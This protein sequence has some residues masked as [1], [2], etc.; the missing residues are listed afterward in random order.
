MSVA[1]ADRRTK[2]PESQRRRSEAIDRANLALWA[3]DFTTGLQSLEQA[4]QLR[5]APALRVVHVEAL[6]ETGQRRAAADLAM[7]YIKRAAA[8]P[9]FERPESDPM[10]HMLARA[11][12]GGAMPDAD[13]TAQREAWLAS[14]RARLDDEA[15]RTAGPVVWAMGYA[16]SAS[17]DDARA[18]VL[19]LSSIG[20][21]PPIA[22]RQF[23][24]NDGPIGE[25]LRLGDRLD[26][27]VPRL[28]AEAN[29][30]TYDMTRVQAQLGLGLSLEARG[31]AAGACSAYAK[32]LSRWG[33][34]KPRSVT[35]EEARARSKALACPP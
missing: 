20:A 24:T 7:D 17:A 2:L 26:D 9:R 32:V 31:D 33:R 22:N 30:C 34:A 18:A 11:H 35:A 21:P 16:Y 28:S 29:R 6:W 14:W 4:A 25:L 1:L 13:F 12:A 10:P 3:G 15:W 19:R 5:P 27:A 8:L 23:W